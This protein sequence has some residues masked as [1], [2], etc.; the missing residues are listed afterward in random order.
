MKQLKP[1]FIGVV[2]FLLTGS[3][4]ISVNAQSYKDDLKILAS[5]EMEGRNTGELGQKKA[6][7]YIVGRFKQMGVSY[8]KQ[9]GSYFQIVP[10]SYMKSRKGKLNDS[11]N[12]LAFIEGAEKPEE[13]VV[14]SAHYDHVGINKGVVFNGADDN[15]SGT[16]A[17]MKM[18]EDFQK[19]KNK[20][21]GPKRSILF[22]L[23]TAEEH[24]LFGSKYYVDNPVFPLENTVVN[25]NID[26]IGR[27]D[28][29]HEKNSNYVYVIGSD[30]LSS[31]LKTINEACNAK[32]S[33]LLLDYKYDDPNDPM[34]L[35]YRSDHY[36][37]AKH[38]VPAAFF[39][40]GIHEDYHKETDDYEKINFPLLQ[41]RMELISATVWEIANRENRIVVDKK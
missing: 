36:S 30:K 9:L 11:E 28:P 2:S 15:A 37:F 22:I 13:I 25:L 23:F 33:K 40:D 10:S 14:V 34:R 27:V 21:K 20:G 7:G 39:F 19:K 12:I 35:Y 3:I 26:M 1:I 4:S 41:K 31:E 8:P 16:V 38:G 32:T 29:E 5:D 18:A 24:G 6:A 17:V